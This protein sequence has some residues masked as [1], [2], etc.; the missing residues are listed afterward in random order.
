MMGTKIMKVPE[1]VSKL[2]K[3]IIVKLKIVTRKALRE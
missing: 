1:N 3:A 2:Y